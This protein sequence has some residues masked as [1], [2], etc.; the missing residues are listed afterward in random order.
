MAETDPSTLRP[1]TKVRYVPSGEIR[2]LARRKDPK[3]G[4]LPGWWLE[5]GG[6]LADAVFDAEEWE[7]VVDVVECFPPAELGGEG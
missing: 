1:G 5:E 7:V 4:P 2:T 3:E 6:G